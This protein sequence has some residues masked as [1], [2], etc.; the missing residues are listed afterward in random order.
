MSPA[1]TARDKAP[2]RSARGEAARRRLMDAAIRVLDRV[3][4]HQ[5]RIKDVTAEAGVA[6][7]LFYHYFKDLRQLVDE[8]LDEHIAEFEAVELIEKDVGKG[9]WFNRLRAHYEICVRVHAEHPGIMRCIAQFS[10]D[11]PVFRERWK[12]SFN[13]RLDLLVEVFPYVFPECP[14]NK[15]QVELLV[16]GL[17]GVG[18]ELMTEYYIDRDPVLREVELSQEAMAE[19]LAALLYRG[20]FACNPPESQLHHALPILTITRN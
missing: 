5:M 20:L 15:A 16:H 6:A 3:G 9:D 1:S 14:L 10:V 18:K 13:R 7:G 17:S 4:V 2:R 19:W 11:D 12:R 8:V